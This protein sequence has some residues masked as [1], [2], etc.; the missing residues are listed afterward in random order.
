ME[1]QQNY[2][3]KAIENKCVL[4]FCLRKVAIVSEDLIVRGNCFH[5]ADVATEK[6]C[7][8][9]VLGTFVGWII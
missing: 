4:S 7:L 6:A 9:L 1:P 3:G 8:R 5:I 2:G